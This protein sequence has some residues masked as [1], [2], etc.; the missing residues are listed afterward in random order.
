M[1]TAAEF[2]SGTGATIASLL[3][4]L[5]HRAAPDRAGRQP[6]PDED[7]KRDDGTTIEINEL[8][9][10][11]FKDTAPSTPRTPTRV[12]SEAPP[13]PKWP[14]APQPITN[15]P[16]VERCLDAVDV[17][18]CLLPLALIVKGFLCILAHEID[19]THVGPSIDMASRLTL[20]L[21]DF[22]A[23]LT[24]LFTIIFIVIVSTTVRRWA[25]WKAEKGA[26]IGE[27][28]QLHASIS[29]TS[30]LKAIW[31][32][33][34]FSL[35]GVGLIFV[36][37][38]Y[39]IGSQAAT[40]EYMYHDSGS[41]S[42]QSV[43]FLDSKSLS[44]FQ[45]DELNK[46]HTSPVRI[47]DMTARFHTYSSFT[48]G[49]QKTNVQG[50]KA[51]QGADIYGATLTPWYGPPRG[52]P[53]GWADLEFDDDGW[54]EI[55]HMSDQ[56]VMSS[57][58]TSLYW[59]NTSDPRPNM[60]T[61][62]KMVGSFVYETSNFQ[63]NCTAPLLSIKEKPRGSYPTISTTMN[64]T[65]ASSD[66]N[67]P[68]EVFFWHWFNETH[69]LT[70]T[71]A[72]TNVTVRID[73]TCTAATCK[74]TR[75]KHVNTSPRTLLDSDVFATAFFN[76]FLLA[77]GMPLR[78]GDYSTFDN[79]NGLVD[80]KNL[81]KQNPQISPD[82]LTHAS[83]GAQFP[84]SM[85]I[86]RFMN[87]YFRSSQ[88]LRYEHDFQS[89]LS[90]NGSLALD[91]NPDFSFLSMD[92]AIFTPQY[93]LSWAWLI[94]DF[95]SNGVLVIAA[96]C[97]FWLRKHTLAPDI[98]GFVSSLTRD[99]PNLHLPEGGSTLGG[100]ERS[101]AMKQVRVKI[102]DVSDDGRVGRVGLTQVA[103]EYEVKDLE[104]GRSYY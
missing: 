58:G 61:P 23:Q 93:S 22:N 86:T 35:T 54:L 95:I 17:L 15:E 45:D 40:R 44:P 77:C 12:V 7:S 97:A 74:P 103:D 91:G 76:S 80:L 24:T 16:L 41:F 9:P 57:I 39:Y 3:Q 51:V 64:T 68:R 101:R 84:L 33:R 53:D 37:S 14:H 47:T 89:D 25:L 59:R 11:H 60:W 52:D 66:P 56:P 96:V 31:S 49:S 81:L 30:T 78:E 26:T 27:I 79:D 65:T 67:R 75:V 73:A 20:A 29:L 34:R 94:M 90:V 18:I 19:K 32:L 71:C 55:S 100:I 83:E 63:A 6:L 38:W 21:I 46:D 28:E 8:Q 36:W 50:A 43:S 82:A 92:G 98:F 69:S 13:L 2:T 104:K 4:H 88:M 10:A 48:A 72:M 87:T 102:A 99:N 42:N 5:Q 62:Q 85:G 70:S 1:S